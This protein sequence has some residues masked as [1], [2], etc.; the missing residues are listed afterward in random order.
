MSKK[1]LE[2]GFARFTSCSG[3]QL[4]LLN[5]ES[6]LPALIEFIQL[7]DFPLASSAQQGQ[8][9]LDVILVEGSI[10][11]PREVSQLLELRRRSQFLIAIGGCALT[12][13]VNAL[14]EIDRQAAVDQIYGDA[15]RLLRTFPPQPINHFVSVDWQI[16][17]CPPERHDLIEA[18][19]SICQGGWPG[20]QQMPVCMECR[21]KENRC[22]L[23]ESHLPC[24]GPITQAGCR[25]RCPSLSVLCE[26]CRGPVAEANRDELFRLLLHTQ[27]PER[28]ACRR[29][30]RF[31]GDQD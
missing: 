26:G 6:Q 19:A 5:C 29:L 21:I 9:Q 18:L 13:G 28:E 27:L 17:G 22:L 10:S 3:C 15:G 12:G 16:P 1:C 11:C 31:G 4:M 23:L 7:H 20:R 14:L 8:Q 30:K 25:A 24:L 2:I